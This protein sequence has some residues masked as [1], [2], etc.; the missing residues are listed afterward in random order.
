MVRAFVP[1][2]YLGRHVA[3]ACEAWPTAYGAY[4]SHPQ[5]VALATRHVARAA[6]GVSRSPFSAPS[7]SSDRSRGFAGLI[8]ENEARREN[9]LIGFGR[10]HTPDHHSR[11]LR[12]RSHRCRRPHHDRPRI[13]NDHRAGWLHPMEVVSGLL[14]AVLGSLRQRAGD[15]TVGQDALNR[16]AKGEMKGTRASLPAGSTALVARLDIGGPVRPV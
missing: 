14:K 12:G 4:A 6:V 9:D 5:T 11:L 2:Q 3:A 13:A 7:A 8:G 1:S 15:L 16:P 10:S